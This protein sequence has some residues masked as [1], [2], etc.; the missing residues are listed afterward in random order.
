[1]AIILIMFKCAIINLVNTLP[2]SLGYTGVSKN[3]IKIEN[4]AE[5]IQFTPFK[6]GNALL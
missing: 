5:R 2:C 6:V 1:M 3:T 4:Y